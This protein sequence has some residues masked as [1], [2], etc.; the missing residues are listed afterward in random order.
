MGQL[1]LGGSG[2][3]DKAEGRR[4]KAEKKPGCDFCLLLCAFCLVCRQFALFF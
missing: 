4:Q 1:R 3:I 2:G